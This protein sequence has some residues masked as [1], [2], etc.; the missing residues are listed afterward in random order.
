M[1][2]KENTNTN[3]EHSINMYCK[4]H[5]WHASQRSR[6]LFSSANTFL[7]CDL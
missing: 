6:P 7:S 2:I 4:I 5:Y 3:S 1:K